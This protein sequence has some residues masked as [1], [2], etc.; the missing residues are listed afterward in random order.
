M[1]SI[2]P[3]AL[4]VIISDFVNAAILGYAAYWA[5]TIRHALG[6]RLYRNQALGIGLVAAASAL[7]ALLFGA[8]IGGNEAVIDLQAFEFLFLFYWIDASVLAARR[9]D[10]IM[11]DD[12]HWSRLRGP[13]WGANLATFALNF[14]AHLPVQIILT[15]VVGVVMLPT[16]AHRSG[17]AIFRRHLRWFGFYVV[18]QII[19]FAGILL[20]YILTGSPTSGST[21]ITYVAIGIFVPGAWGGAYC[22]YRS[23]RSLAP[24]NKISPVEFTSLLSRETSVRPNTSFGGLFKATNVQDWHRASC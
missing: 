18:L 20:P 23:A 17:D 19:A 13:L 9:S 12:Y 10:P 1:S 16:A 14:F 8:T 24:L 11:R 6:V 15:L 3:L 4:T 22:L 7:L 5:L 21:N 2:D